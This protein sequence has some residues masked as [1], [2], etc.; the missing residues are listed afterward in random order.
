M[1]RNAVMHKHNIP[2]RV[3]QKDAFTFKMHKQFSA[4][5]IFQYQVQLPASLEGINQL[6]DEWML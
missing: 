2:C 6:D 1:K 4:A 5:E 3:F